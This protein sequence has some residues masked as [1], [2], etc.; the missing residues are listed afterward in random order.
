MKYPKLEYKGFTAS[1]KLIDNKFCGKFLRIKPT[2]TFESVNDDEAIKLAFEKSVDAYLQLNDVLKTNLKKPRKGSGA[3]SKGSAFERDIAKQLTTM[4]G[5]PFQRSAHSGAFFG[6]KNSFRRKIASA[7]SNKA[8]TGDII[9]PDEFNLII[10]CKNYGSFHFYNLFTKHKILDSWLEQLNRDCYTSN[11]DNGLLFF[12]ISNA[13]TFFAFN[14]SML[15][16]ATFNVESLRIPFTK[17]V[18][19]DQFYY[20]VDFEFFHL[21]VDIFRNILKGIKCDI[22]D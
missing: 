21:F 11:I 13:S 7:S 4:F 19:N 10:E 9:T 2:Y 17:Y 6:G 3:K 12:K 5:L 8:M 22:K 14:A 18:Y 1:Y 16:A 15:P 20:I